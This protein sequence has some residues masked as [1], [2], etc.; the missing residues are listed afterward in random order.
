VGDAP[1]RKTLTPLSSELRVAEPYVP[2]RPS[3]WRGWRESRRKPP[4]TTTGGAVLLGI[5]RYVTALAIAVGVV[6]GLGLLAIWAADARPERAFP[7]AFYLGGVLVAGGGAFASA[8]MGGSDWYW[9]QHEKEQRVSMSFVFIAV[10]LPII[11]AGVVI[12]SQT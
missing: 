5:K 4:P 2:P 12:D 3:R 8:D 9:T 6:V 7:L 11:V 1:K 10:G